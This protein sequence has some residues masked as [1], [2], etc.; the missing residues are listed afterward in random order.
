MVELFW[1]DAETPQSLSV[2][3]LQRVQSLFLSETGENYS[4]VQLRRLPV[5]QNAGS[6]ILVSSDGR[7]EG[8]LWVMNIDNETVRVIGFCISKE[9]QNSGHGKKGWS[10][11]TEIAKNNGRKKVYLEVKA[12]N[13]GAI[14][15]YRV[16]G[17]ETIGFL[18]KYYHD[19]LGVVMS[20]EL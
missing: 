5:S 4:L 1:K 3:E 16:W 6:Q 14:R 7:I 17:L 20:G 9:Y 11:F 13:H 19:G 2:T 18:K 10:M 15:F 8:A 12:S